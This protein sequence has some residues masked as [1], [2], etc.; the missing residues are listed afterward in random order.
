MDKIEEI[1]YMDSGIP[2]TWTGSV[3]SIPKDKRIEALTTLIQEAKKEGYRDAMKFVEKVTDGKVGF[4][5]K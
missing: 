1:L 2:E 4:V 5:E 3:E